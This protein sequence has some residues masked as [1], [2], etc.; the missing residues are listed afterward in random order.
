MTKIMK[1]MTK[2][3]SALSEVTTRNAQL[4]MR[5][6]ELIH[7]L[8]FMP[9]AMREKIVQAKNGHSRF[10]SE[11]RTNPHYLVPDVSSCLD[12][13]FLVLSCLIVPLLL[14]LWAKVVVR[15]VSVISARAFRSS[16]MNSGASSQ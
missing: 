16:D 4:A 8:S 2:L 12:L 3:K 13:S 14:T 7:E 10:F 6:S 1:S 5:N 11:Q 9:P 15:V